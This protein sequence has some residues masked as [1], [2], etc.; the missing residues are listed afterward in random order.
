LSNLVVNILINVKSKK[1]NN[2][3]LE[4]KGEGINM[5]KQSEKVTSLFQRKNRNNSKQD[6]KR[7][8]RK[9]YGGDKY[10]FQKYSFEF[11]KKKTKRHAE[12]DLIFFYHKIEKGLSLPDR[13][14]GFG[15]KHINHLV[16]LLEKYVLNYGWD[17]MAFAAFNILYEYYHF[18]ESQGLK[19]RKL[20]RK[21]KKI[22]STLPENEHLDIG[23]AFKITKNEIREKVN[24]NFRDF[25]WSRYSIRD[26]AEGEVS[27][28]LI[29]EA[30]H[31]AQKTPSVCNRQSSKVHV[32]EG[33][34][35]NEVLKL[36][37]GGSAFA[38]KAN[39]ILI[40]TS[41]LRDFRGVIE[42]NQSYI[43]GGMYAMSLIYALHSLGMGT[44]ALNLSITNNQ[45]RQLKR[46]ASINDA[47]TLIMMIA[48]GVLPEEFSVASSP[49]RNAQEVITIH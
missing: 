6:T 12:A 38:R 31:I 30:V 25:A 7:N 4:I 43:D 22:E 2:E 15:K 48:V 27:L 17:K 19:L 26:F 46:T 33:S 29:E 49:R 14:I 5:F 47:E 11:G 20:Y 45:E 8:L 16:S 40:V 21:L 10:R 18:N 34:K 23:G 44:C 32:Y 41:D 24:S 9:N 35:K 39:K 3:G 42:R 37:K 13:R 28:N 1:V 36:H